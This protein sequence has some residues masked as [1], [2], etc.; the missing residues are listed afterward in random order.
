M[1]S[2]RTLQL[3]RLVDAKKS[4]CEGCSLLVRATASKHQGVFAFHRSES[5]LQHNTTASPPPPPPHLMVPRAAAAAPI[6]GC[7]RAGS[8]FLRAELKQRH[9]GAC[10]QA[11]HTRKKKKRVEDTGWVGG[12]GGG[13]RVKRKESCTIPW[14]LPSRRV[15]GEGAGLRYLT[16]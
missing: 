15:V 6:E 10:M 14:W 16:L 4:W 7:A 8:E 1:V 12:G 5:V 2:R 13:W 3:M 9:C 11:G